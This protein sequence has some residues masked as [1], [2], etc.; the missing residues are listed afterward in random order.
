[1][2]ETMRNR[3][4][5]KFPDFNIK[6]KIVQSPNLQKKI[7][8]NVIIVIVAA[9]VRSTIFTIYVCYKINYKIPHCTGVGC[10]DADCPLES[11]EI[12][13]SCTV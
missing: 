1:M 11:T 3:F 10:G 13:L 9:T 5:K 2:Q 8:K 4:K 12:I 7:Y 6:W